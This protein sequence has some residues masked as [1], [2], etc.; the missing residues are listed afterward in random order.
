MRKPRLALQLLILIAP[1]LSAIGQTYKIDPGHTSIAS[2]VMRFGVVKVVGWFTNVSGSVSYDAADPGKT[3]AEI[4]VAADSY[5]ANN[6]EGEK[7]VK[8]QTFL[9]AA[10]FPEIK[11]V[12]KG[13]VKLKVDSKSLPIFPCME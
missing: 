7:A 5:V 11:V 3:K 12:V 4:V 2:K 1:I 13:L 8:G 10:S 9:D 6:P